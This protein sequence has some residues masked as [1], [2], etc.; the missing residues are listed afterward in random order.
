MKSFL[1]FFSSIREYTRKNKLKEVK[2]NYGKL[3]FGKL[4]EVRRE[5]R[6]KR[7]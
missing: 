2:E 1:P 6:K 4:N 7:K 5:E 3:N